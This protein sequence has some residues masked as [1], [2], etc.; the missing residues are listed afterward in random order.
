M[1]TNGKLGY[2]VESFPTLKPAFVVKATGITEKFPVGDVYTGG[3]LIAV[4][5]YK[6]TVESIGDFDPK[7]KFKV[8]SGCDYFKIDAGA[9]HGRLIVKVIFTDDEGRS[10]VMEAF[11]ITEL[12]DTVMPILMG[13]PG[14]GDAPWGYSMEQVRFEAGHEYYK[15]LEHKL[16]VGSQR[17]TTG[18]DGSLQVE[19]RASQIISGTG[20][21]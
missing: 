8:S 2:P 15:S 19:I 3:N 11:A 9:T 5:F 21:E 13:Q 6:G 18:P 10:V 12:N 4:P 16:F 7:F 14:A 1:S 17:F 20:T